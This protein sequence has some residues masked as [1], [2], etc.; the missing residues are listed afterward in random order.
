MWNTR[1]TTLLL[2]VIW[3]TVCRMIDRERERERERERGRGDVFI[4]EK[5]D[6]REKTESGQGH[7]DL[8]RG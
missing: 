3:G 5:S 2:L 6:E 1:D 8:W 4:E 7:L